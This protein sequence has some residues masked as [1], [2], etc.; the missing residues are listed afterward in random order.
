MREDLHHSTYPLL[1]A[2][3]KHTPRTILWFNL[4]ASCIAGGVRQGAYETFQAFFS[5]SSRVSLLFRTLKRSILTQKLCRTERQAG[6]RSGDIIQ[7]TSATLA[8][9]SH[10]WQSHCF[11]TVESML[12]L[13]FQ[14]TWVPGGFSFR[15]AYA[16]RQRT[17]VTP[18]GLLETQRARAQPY[19]FH[20]NRLYVL[21]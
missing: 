2:S 21:L 12:D 6:Q 5:C 11:A 1:K 19:Q 10:L 9:D 13:W 18:T 14:G 15:R 16:L 20:Y 4:C 3:E 17:T 7:R 8:R